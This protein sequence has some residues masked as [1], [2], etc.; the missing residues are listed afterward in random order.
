MTA[1]NRSTSVTSSSAYL[2]IRN[3]PRR[4][5]ILCSLL[6]IARSRPCVIIIRS[7]LCPATS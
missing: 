1:R 7:S 4:I 6:L 5:V 2:Q 3:S